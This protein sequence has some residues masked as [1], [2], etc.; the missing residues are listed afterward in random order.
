MKKLITALMSLGLI[1]SLIA[2]NQ[3]TS[4]EGENPKG[5]LTATNSAPTT[6]DAEMGAIV[7]AQMSR[8][9]DGM[10]RQALIVESFSDV[11]QSLHQVFEKYGVNFDVK[12]ASLH[13]IE[14]TAALSRTSAETAQADSEAATRLF[15]T[16]LQAALSLFFTSTDLNDP[17]QVQLLGEVAM[18][19][20]K[21]T[22]PALIF[23]NNLDEEF[24]T[25]A[26]YIVETGTPQEGVVNESVF[27]NL[28]TN[29]TSAANA[30]KDQGIEPAEFSDVVA[31]FATDHFH[32]G[33]NHTFTYRMQSQ[34]TTGTQ[35]IE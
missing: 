30:L 5:A 20:F 34:P 14:L 28:V 4:T 2:G 23:D 10:A 18:V 9:R 11:A 35:L 19:L 24:A 22:H 32:H 8:I 27:E 33:P 17:T 12:G 6:C 31:L 3:A 16:N 13:D 7:A 25:F 21:T 15:L 1:S 26:R 29:I